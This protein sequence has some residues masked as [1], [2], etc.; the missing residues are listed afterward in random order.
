MLK[1]DLGQLAR[2][3]RLPIEARVPAD[4]VLNQDAGFRMRGPLEIQLEAMQTGPDVLVQ[5]KL[6]GEAEVLCRRCLRPVAS[7]IAEEV[8]L[9][10]REGVSEAEAEAEEAEVFPLPER[11]HELDLTRAIREHLVLS[12][13]DLAICSE[14][15]KGLCPSCGANLNET[16]CNCATADVDE[17]WAVLKRIKDQDGRS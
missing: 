3:Q 17:R 1:L 12:V 10:F 4:L 15:C 14:T 6:E 13:P 9:V 11:G 2:Y 5:G 16:T 7:P 8:A